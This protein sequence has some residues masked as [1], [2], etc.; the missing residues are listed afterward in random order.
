MYDDT[1]W[2]LTVIAS[3][4]V[5]LSAFVLNCHHSVD[6]SWGESMAEELRLAETQREAKVEAEA[7]RDHEISK[8]SLECSIDELSVEREI[9]MELS[10][11]LG[12]A[13]LAEIEAAGRDVGSMQEFLRGAAATYGAYGW[14]RWRQRDWRELKGMA[15]QAHE[16][17]AALQKE[18]REAA[19]LA[20]VENYS[21]GNAF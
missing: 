2:G 6:S 17:Y 20:Q 21:K 3:L 9:A 4:A 8:K 11:R 12:P 15:N 16:E 10:R 19:S 5:F 1:I 13:R 18:L 14:D 7:K